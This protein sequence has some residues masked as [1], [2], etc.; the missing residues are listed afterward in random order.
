[1]HV[2]V[3]LHSGF[4]GNDVTSKRFSHREKMYSL[5]NVSADNCVQKLTCISNDALLVLIREVWEIYLL[6]MT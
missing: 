1:M 4:V 5:R 2:L 3:F 6:Y